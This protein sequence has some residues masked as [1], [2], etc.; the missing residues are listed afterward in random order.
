MDKSLEDSLE[1]F[2]ARRV[3]SALIEF[4]DKSYHKIQ[5]LGDSGLHSQNAINRAQALVMLKTVL[6]E[7]LDT[8]K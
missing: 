1:R 5:G 6:D 7:M 8:S 3:S 4:Y 2:A